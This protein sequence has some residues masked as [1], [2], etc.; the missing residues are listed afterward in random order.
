[1]IALNKKSYDHYIS[2]KL[3]ED[4]NENPFATPVNLVANVENGFGH[5]GLY[6]VKE[7]FVK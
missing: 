3:Y 1:V 5:F 4:A 6:N 7:V 2:K